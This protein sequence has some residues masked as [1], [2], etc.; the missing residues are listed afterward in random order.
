MKT[1]KSHNTN[2]LFPCQFEKQ[3][4]LK[5]EAKSGKDTK[6]QHSD[7]KCWW[8]SQS[9]TLMTCAWALIIRLLCSFSSSFFKSKVY[10]NLRDALSTNAACCTPRGKEKR[11]NNW[12]ILHFHVQKDERSFINIKIKFTN[13]LVN[14]HNTTKHTDSLA[15]KE[16]ICNRKE[17]F[18]HRA[19]IWKNASH[20]VF[21]WMMTEVSKFISV[22]PMA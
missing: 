12:F 5:K 4:C 21:F 16:N 22:H 15:L 1:F 6:D 8:K 14:F 17:A 7:R 9:I 20:F 13:N 10:L 18:S 2:L 3:C 19:L 11:K